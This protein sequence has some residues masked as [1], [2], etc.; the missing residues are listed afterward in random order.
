MIDDP[1]AIP[2]WVTY[3][4]IASEAVIVGCLASLVLSELGSRPAFGVNCVPKPV[5]AWLSSLKHWLVLASTNHK[6]VK[7]QGEPWGKPQG[8]P[9]RPRPL[10]SMPAGGQITPFVSASRSLGLSARGGLFGSSGHGCVDGGG[11]GS[12]WVAAAV[13]RPRMNSNAYFIRGERIR[14]IAVPD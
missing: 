3:G 6:D 11:A 2:E 14:R 8:R 13:R 7:R 1:T 5:A 4:F 9:G 10:G 12:A